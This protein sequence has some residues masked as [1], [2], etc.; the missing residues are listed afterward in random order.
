MPEEAVFLV[1]KRAAVLVDDPQAQTHSTSSAG[2]SVHQLRRW[3]KAQ[4]DAANQ[5]IAANQMADVRNT[6]VSDKKMSADAIRKRAEREERKR[7]K[8]IALAFAAGEEYEEHFVP[9]EQPAPLSTPRTSN[10]VSSQAEQAVTVI[11]PTT[12][13]THE[14]YQPPP[15]T[16]YDTIEAAQCSGLWYFP[17]TEHE[18]SRCAV[19]RDLWEK[20]HFMGGGTKFGAEYLVY[21][22][23]PLRYHSHQAATVLESP[24]AP[25][26]GIEIVAHG[27]LG[28]AT[29]KAHLLCAWDEEAD[30]VDYISIEW[31]GFG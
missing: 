3:A 23:D 26:Q 20:G 28:T 11:I 24:T 10:S 27:R 30:Q 22:G 9:T 25:M 13:T 19:F 14:W 31:A 15:S 7:Q 17:R 8:A 5:Q 2:L 12:A 1:N 21:P 16:V 18:R 6:C 29:K 4:K